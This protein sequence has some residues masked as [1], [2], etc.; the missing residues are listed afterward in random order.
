MA[1]RI[2]QGLITYLL[3]VL[4]IVLMLMAGYVSYSESL[5]FKNQW[6]DVAIFLF[7]LCLVCLAGIRIGEI[8]R[9]S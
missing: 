5:P 9:H 6:L 7:G 4:G 2:I 1:K 3:L 8:H